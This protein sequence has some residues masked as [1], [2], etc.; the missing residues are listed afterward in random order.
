MVEHFV[1]TEGVRSS[2]L[3]PPKAFGD[4]ADSKF[5][6]SST[7]EGHIGEE[8]SISRN[9]LVHQLQDQWIGYGCGMCDVSLTHWSIESALN[10]PSLLDLVGVTI[11]GFWGY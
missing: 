6:L 1:Y 11:D 10:C 5:Y 4:R 2:S 3:L 7:F 8:L 9:D